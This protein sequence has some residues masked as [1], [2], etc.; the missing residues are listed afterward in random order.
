MPEY[1]SPG[2]YIEEFEIG[3]RPIEGV[4]TSTAG[5]LGVTLRGPQ[6]PRLINGF[7]QFKRLYG[8]YMPID[9]SNMAYAVDGFFMNGGQRCFVGRIVAQDSVI[10]TGALDTVNI[11]AIGPGQWGNRIALKVE[12][13]SLVDPVNPR[14]KLTVM[15]WD[16]LPPAAPPVDPTNPANATN[17]DRREPVLLEV[18]DNLSADQTSID[19]FETRIN[20]NKEQFWR[21]KF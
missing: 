18:Y 9:D 13:G 16:V 8:G 10:M 1:L 7:E 21:F 11:G 4:S 14:I 3:A 20:K 12:E 2:V 15:Y 6:D 17:P 5:F 19:Y